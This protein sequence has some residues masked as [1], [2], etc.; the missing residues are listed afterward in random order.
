MRRCFIASALVFAAVSLASPS[1][2]TPPAA[3]PALLVLSVIDVKPDMFAEFGEVQAQAM[4]AQR[5]GGQRWRETWNVATFG[6]PYRVGVL[7]PLSSFAE[8]DG[9]SFTVKG[10]GAEEARAISERARRMIVAQR[11]Y[12]LRPRPD[13]G[14]G[15]RPSTMNLAVLTT[16]TVAPGRTA[17][18]EALIRNDVIPAYKKAGETYLAM[19]QVALGGNPAE[20]LAFTLYDDFASLQKGNPILRGLG[21]EAFAAFRQ[22]LAGLLVREEHDVVRY[23]PAL[24]FRPA[25]TP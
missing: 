13:L 11:I 21:P 3:P 17:D 8:L 19:A 20:Y 6:Q 24:S 7:H 15:T 22:R 16:V 9:Q 1:A 4:K 5:A 10:A 25:A 12:A 14:F 23:N 2:Q 18:Y